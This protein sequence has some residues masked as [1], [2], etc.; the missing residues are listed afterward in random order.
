M[1]ATPAMIE[2][3][4][5]EAV[6]LELRKPGYAPVTKTVTASGPAAQVA[7]DLVPQNGFEGVWALPDGQLRAFL[8]SGEAVDIYKLKTVA[9]E[10]EFYRKLPLEEPAG[11]APAEEVVFAASELMTDRRAPHEP[12]CQISHRI[13]YHYDPRGDVLAVRPEKVNVG[14]VDG[15][16]VVHEKQPGAPLALVRADRGADD[17]RWS[18]APVGKPKDIVLPNDTLDNKL[19]VPQKQVPNVPAPP[20]PAPVTNGEKTLKEAKLKEAKTVK[21]PPS[22]E[23]AL[24]NADAAGADANIPLKPAPNAPPPQPAPVPRPPQP[25]PQPQAPPQQALP[26]QAPPPRGDAQVAPQVPQPDT[27]AQE[28]QQRV[29]PKQTKKK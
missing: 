16:C 12:S 25:A 11:A 17:G 13:E 4:V 21:R 6:A 1:G 15:R 5:G 24:G 20:A 8:R 26:Q 18:Q 14:F 3:R 22:K 9:G 27:G 28:Q 10:R 2:V 7:L 29:T 19:D 23:A